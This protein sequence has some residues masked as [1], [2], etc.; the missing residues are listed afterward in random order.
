[1]M[2]KRIIL[3]VAVFAAA[4]LALT[5]TL[6]GQSVRD[7]NTLPW[8]ITHP[9][10][11][12]L[13]VLGLTLGLSTLDEAEKIYQKKAAISIFKSADSKLA[14]EALFDEVNL[15]GL[16]ARILLAI[17]IPSYELPGLF[18]RASRINTASTGQHINLHPDDLLRVHN[19]SI[20]GLSYFPDTGFNE[21]ELIERFG[22]PAKRVRET[23]TGAIHWLYPKHGLDITLNGNEKP[24][25]QYLLP[26]EFDS[27]STSVL[28]QGEIL[29]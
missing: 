18:E 4:A 8:N 16:K 11:D 17:E 27:K 2:N 6:P 13:H 21:T 7:S 15:N 22:S 10:H 19:A 23:G 25:L 3:G 28:A 29:K 1:M 12:T 14:V 26:A 20:L 9:T 5:L 24:L